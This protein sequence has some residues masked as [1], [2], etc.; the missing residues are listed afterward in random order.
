M[1]AEIKTGDDSALLKENKEDEEEFILKI[2][3]EHEQ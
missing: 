3:M 2:K 1:T